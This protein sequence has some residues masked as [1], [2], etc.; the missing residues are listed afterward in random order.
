M[1][2]LKKYNIFITLS[3]FAKG[4]IEIFIPLIMYEAGYDIKKILIFL[5]IKF[6]FVELFLPLSSIIG[7]KVNFKNL[8]I[9]SNFLFIGMNIYFNFIDFK[10]YQLVIFASL[11]AA[12]LIFYWMGRHI[13]GMSI[14]ED[15]KITEN[16]SSYTIFTLI[17]M[18][19]AAYIGAL[20]LNKFGFTTLSIVLL[21]IST[22]SV[23]PLSFIK[24][25][26]SK[27][28]LDFKNILRI[29]PIKSYIFIFLEQVKHLSM[30]LF[31]LYVF[32]EISKK[33]EYIGISNAIVCIASIIYVYFLAKIMDKNKKDYLSLASILLAVVWFL[34]LNIY[35]SSLI[36]VIM[37]FEG[38]FT[39]GLETIILRNI[40]SFGK[41]YKVL[42]Y[43]LFME[44][45]RNTSR[46]I[47]LI[48]F[49]I[50]SVNL[51]V[52]L[53]AGVISL[54]INAIIKFDDGKYGYKK[55]TIV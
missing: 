21:I 55:R 26:V 18:L 27:E 46:I 34:K 16:V 6:L 54:I 50:L 8:I 10:F 40:Y 44:A 22:I 13:Y 25:N 23:I 28:K 24:E 39:F 30:G 12:Y 2:K 52:V 5:L 43:N 35:S 9:L 19:P 14:I 38:I 31:P 49:I 29:F 20:I 4:M 1:S 51:K 7:K 41:E 42:S 37:F 48:I 32:I 15:K 3:S 47:I 17:G 45:L 33:Y 53:Y 36:L 11:Y